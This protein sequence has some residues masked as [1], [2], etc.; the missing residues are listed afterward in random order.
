MSL[1]E[2]RLYNRFGRSAPADSFVSG[3]S[4]NTSSR[5]TSVSLSQPLLRGSGSDV[6]LLNERRATLALE[7]AR[8]SFLQTRRDVVLNGVLAYFALEQ[9]KQNLTLAQAALQRA[10]EARSI[11]EA[12]LAAGRI[13]R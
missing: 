2:G 4:L 8:R 1:S 7:S 5:V 11:N 3:A 6:V 13:A 10:N 12:L 9:A